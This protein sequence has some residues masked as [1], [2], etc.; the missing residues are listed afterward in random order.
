MAPATNQLSPQAAATRGTELQRL[1]RPPT[2]GK[3]LT[4]G[5]RR[6]PAP[7][8]H[9]QARQHQT[10]QLLWNQGLNFDALAAPGSQS[11]CPAALLLL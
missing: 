1:L 8:A 6:K 2:P 7:E 3:A 10:S 11:S 5:G 4:G 9:L